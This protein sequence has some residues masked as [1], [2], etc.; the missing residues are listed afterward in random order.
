MAQK[1]LI[2]PACDHIPEHCRT[3]ACA[4]PEDTGLPGKCSSVFDRVAVSHLTR[5]CST[6]F[7]E[8]REDFYGQRPFTFQLQVGN[9]NSSLADDWTNVGEPV[10]DQFIATDP[11][12]RRWGKLN[13]VHY[14][15]QITTAE[16]AVSFSDP[17]GASGTLAPRDWRYAREL[18]RQEIL[19]M[20]DGHSAQEG[21]LLKRRVTGENCPTCLDH[22]TEEITNPEC[23]DCYGTGKR[24]GYFFPIC[25]VW[26]DFQPKTYRAH[27][28]SGQARGTVM[29]IVLRARMINTWLLGEEDVWINRRTDDRYFIHTVQNVVEIRG[30]PIAADVELRLAPATDI[31]YD[32]SLPGQGVPLI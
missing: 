24:C 7:W 8:L 3:G 6:I 4:T 12:Q 29:D 28:D 32:L 15:V 9:T 1:D 11:G 10:V 31:I 2:D 25:D 30:F 22:I 21:I 23:P 5:G 14:R 16:G 20:K 13:R 19:Q 27:L 26:A 17:I 18:L